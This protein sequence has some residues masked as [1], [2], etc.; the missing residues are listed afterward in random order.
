MQWDTELWHKIAWFLHWNTYLAKD[1]L[2]YGCFFICPV[3]FPAALTE[4]LCQESGVKAVSSV[5]L[6]GASNGL[7]VEL[8]ARLDGPHFLGRI[9]RWARKNGS[10]KPTNK[11]YQIYTDDWL[12][13]SVN[14]VS[15]CRRSLIRACDT[16]AWNHLITNS[17]N[18]KCV[19]TVTKLTAKFFVS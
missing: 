6:R 9:Q 12:R 3:G 7:W 14:P 1:F 4:K 19:D 15:F 16:S 2:T 18:K 5:E 10:T 8:C 11:V 17:N 13:W